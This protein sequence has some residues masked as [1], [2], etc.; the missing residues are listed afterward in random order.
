MDRTIGQWVVSRYR[1]PIMPP[2]H[3]VSAHQESVRS[4]VSREI[5]SASIGH[6]SRTSVRHNQDIARLLD[7]VLDVALCFPLELVEGFERVACVVARD[8]W[9]AE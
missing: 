6:Q 3:S 1:P 4:Q 7:A 8:R 5:K 9:G 2:A